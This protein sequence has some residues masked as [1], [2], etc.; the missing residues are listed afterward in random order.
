[1]SNSQFAALFGL[2]IGGVIGVTTIILAVVKYVITAMGYA[3]MFGKA[4]EPGWKAFVPFYNEYILFKTCWTTN[5][6]FVS[7]ILSILY[8]V[9]DSLG[10]NFFLKLLGFVI[11]IPSL[12]VDAK[13]AMNVSKAFN[14]GIGTA[15]G[16]FFFPVI[17]SWILGFGS[18][19]YMGPVE[20]EFS[21]F[22]L[23]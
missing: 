2:L 18:A 3:K 19:E 21:N 14:R 16:C 9:V 12:L 22:Q 10:D 20:D 1:M 23:K 13:K 7:L 15:V 11:F 5:M 4:G 17:F 8:S 6:F